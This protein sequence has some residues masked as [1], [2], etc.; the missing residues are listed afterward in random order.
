MADDLITVAD[1][2]ERLGKDKRHVFKVLNRLSIERSLQRRDSARGQKVACIS[3]AD[4]RRLE[5]YFES[6]ISNLSDSEPNDRI[7]DAESKGVFYLIQ[8]EP[9][10]DP[11][12]FKLGFATNI[13]ERLRSH[14]TAAPLCQVLNT[15]PCKLLW[16]KTAI[17]FITFGAE[18]L[19]TEVFRTNL[20]EE[21]ES[22][23]NS[24]FALAP[25]LEERQ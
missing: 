24:F 13:D 17:E 10:F 15:W 6:I 19:H 5:E 4:F 7:V 22:R 20:I 21:I 1:A 9:E 14:K 11:G 12:R 25:Q 16:E 3:L 8:L 2:A 23:C 18:R